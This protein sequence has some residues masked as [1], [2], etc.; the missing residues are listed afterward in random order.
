MHMFMAF[1]GFVCAQGKWINQIDNEYEL[2]QPTTAVQNYP[3]ADTNHADEENDMFESYHMLS[4][5]YKMHYA[6]TSSIEKP[7]VMKALIPTND[8]NE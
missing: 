7:I 6:D 1:A 5:R 2:L 4:L 3:E 8:S